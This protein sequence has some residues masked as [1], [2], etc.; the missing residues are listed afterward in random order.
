MGDYL[1]KIFS[2]ILILALFTGCNGSNTKVK[3]ILRGIS[4]LCEVTYYNE[5]YEFEGDVQSNGDTVISFKSPSEIEGLKFSFTKNGVMANFNEIEYVSQNKVF[6]NSAA[7]FV[8]EVL[9]SADSEVLKEDDVFYTQG[10]TDEFEYRLELG[11]TGLPI[12]ITTRPD[13]VCVIFK[14]VKIK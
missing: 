2:V 11:Q 9:W 4:F 3:P 14:N 6:E 7:S 5:V 8:Y 1:K 12:K 13:A 10:V